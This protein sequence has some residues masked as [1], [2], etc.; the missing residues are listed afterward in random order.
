M[1][2]KPLSI[3]TSMTIGQFLCRRHRSAAIAWWNFPRVYPQS[4][5]CSTK[6]SL[7]KVR[8]AELARR[9]SIPRQHVNRLLN[10]RHA[11]EIDNVAAALKALG[12]TPE[13]RAV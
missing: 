11:T 6:C 3:S 1:R 9:L 7:K 10:P 12:K 4:S 13:I 2:S 8:P 5:S